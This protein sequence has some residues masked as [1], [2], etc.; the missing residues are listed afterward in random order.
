MKKS[1]YDWCIENGKEYLLKEWDYAKNELTPK[2]YTPKKQESVWWKCS[3][4]HSWQATIANRS[5]KG[6]MCK[7]CRDIERKSKTLVY[8]ARPELMSI[9]D[10]EK[11]GENTPYNTTIR[12]NKEIWWYCS[13]CNSS[14]SSLIIN[15]ES[16]GCPFCTGHKLKK[17]YNDLETWCRKNNLSILKMY[18]DK[19]QKKANE[20]TFNNA[21]EVIWSCPKFNYIWKASVNS[22]VARSHKIDCLNCNKSNVVIN[23]NNISCG[24]SLKDRTMRNFIKKNQRYQ[25]MQKWWSGKNNID[26]LDVGYGVGE[27]KFIWKCPIGHTFERSFNGMYI[28]ISCPVCSKSSR[29]SF[30]ELLLGYELRKC[31]PNLKTT[32]GKNYFEWIGK[33]SIDIYIPNYKIAIEY[34]GHRHNDK[35]DM[36]NRKDELCKEH[37][38]KLIRVRYK[39]LPQT[40]YAYHIWVEKGTNIEVCNSALEIVNLINNYYKENKKLNIDLTADEREVSKEFYNHLRENSLGEKYPELAKE[41]DIKK[42]GG[43]NPYYIPFASNI[44]YWWY[45]EKCDTSWEQTPNARTQ[46]GYAHKC[47]YCN[48]ERVKKGFNDIKTTH[49]NVLKDWDYRKNKKSPEEFMAG[50]HTKVWWECHNCGNEW[51]TEIRY[52]CLRHTKCPVC[53]VKE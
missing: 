45:C 33:M 44:S 52:R 17:G 31:F 21:Q 4:G 7:E 15:K 49:P 26:F 8:I 28:D 32:V 11:N 35:L 25:D 27:S 13:K 36:D 5:D 53:L 43:L 46:K 14:W 1:L 24:V 16:D 22:V 41:F 20:M 29:V 47:P 48:N 18:S 39:G 12:E 6:H 10:Y 40:Q 42:N 23:Q 34:D 50:S 9:W 51:D 30:S 3:R 38:V 19:N 2:D 37:G